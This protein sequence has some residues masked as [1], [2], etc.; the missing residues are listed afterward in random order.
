MEKLLYIV[1]AL[2]TYLDLITVLGLACISIV[3]I[4]T[5]SLCLDLR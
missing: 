3:L 2:Y 1:N 5:C 4:S